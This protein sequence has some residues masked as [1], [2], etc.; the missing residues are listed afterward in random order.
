MAAVTI[1]PHEQGSLELNLWTLAVCLILLLTP[2]CLT[3]SPLPVPLLLL[4]L[5][6]L[7]RINKELLDLGKDPPA[8]CSAGPVTDDLYHWQASVSSCAYFSS[9]PGSL[10]PVVYCLTQTQHTGVGPPQP[11]S[12]LVDNVSDFLFVYLAVFEA[13]ED[14]AGRLLLPVNGSG[15]DV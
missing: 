10:T 15:S 2:A 11:S 12:R 6:A 9:L 5:T 8:N 1:V 7:K 3:T 14:K 13:S 4:P